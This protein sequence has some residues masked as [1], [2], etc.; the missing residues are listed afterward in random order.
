MRDVFYNTK[1]LT[2]DQMREILEQARIDSGRWEVHEKNEHYARIPSSKTFG[3]MMDMLDEKCH[4][5]IVERNITFGEEEPYLEIGFCT[6]GK[7]FPG[8]YFLFIVVPSEK[9]DHY[10]KKYDRKVL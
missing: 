4:S 7:P 6:M 1:N 2:L 3:E 5:F 9:L 8:D 10:L